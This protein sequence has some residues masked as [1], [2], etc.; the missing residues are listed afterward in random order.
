MKNFGNFKDAINWTS[1]Q[2]YDYSHKVHTE[3]WQA[4]DIKDDPRYT[5]IEILNHSFTCQINDD[6]GCLKG[7]IKPNIDWADEHFNERVGG[8]PLNPPPSHERWPYAQKNNAEFGGLEKFS[9]TYPERIWPKFASDVPNSKMEGIRYEYGDFSDVVNLMHR[10]PFTRQAFLPIWFPEDTGAV[11]GQRVPCFVEGTLV[12]TSEGYKE[13]EKIKEGDLVV[14]HK[15]RFRK[16]QKTFV[17]K[18]SDQLIEIRTINTNIP[19]KTTKDHPFL[20]IRDQSKLPSDKNFIWKEEWVKAEDIC[21]GDYVVHSFIGETE[22][23]EYSEDL[24]RLFGYY[25]AEGDIMYDKRSGGK[26]P[27]ATRFNMSRKDLNSGY[28]DDIINIIRKEFN[29]EVYIK[30]STKNDDKKNLRIYFHDV[31]FA[32]KIH[33]L[34]G[35]GSYEKK[36]PEEILKADA[37]LQYQLLIGY[38]RGDGSFEKRKKNIECT[39]VSRSIIMGL[40]TICLRN[41]INTSLLESKLRKPYFNKRLKRT[42]KPNYQ[43]YKLIFSQAG[44]LSEDFFGIK[45]NESQRKIY[46]K[47][48]IKN[49]R[50]L[51]KVEKLGIHETQEIPVYNLQVE[52]DNTYNIINCTVHNCTIGYQFIRRFDWVHVVYYIRSC[53]FFR[54]FRDDI[55]L[56]L[57]KLFWLIEELKKKD[58]ETWKNVKPGTY[59]M[60]ICSLHAWASEKPLLLK[61]RD[62]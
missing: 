24:M 48:Y 47:S 56:C 50:V 13:I 45:D 17:S 34:F 55:Y 39:S 57:R 35:S 14:T 12:Q 52:D 15:G 36:I 37:K 28:I 22:E 49:N 54:H 7:Q 58:Y 30:E 25:L 1:D 21:T 38:T 8:L 5:M 6:L 32:K 53:D 4:K 18:Y 10:E 60:H 42:I 19:I 41:G 46:K 16:V 20:V 2:M 61:K 29:K 9:H 11:E 26:N 51:Y 33:D 43:S 23:I 59:T 3:K 62:I 31:N 44:R 27:K 40:R